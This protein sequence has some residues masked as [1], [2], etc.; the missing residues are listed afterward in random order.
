MDKAAPFVRERVRTVPTG[1]AEDRRVRRT[2]AAL[3]FALIRL[4]LEKRY[5]A[6]TIQNLL[7]RADVGRSTFYSHFRGKDDL[8]L[9]SWGRL[10]EGLD[11][12]MDQCCE[13]ADPARR[14][15]APVREL[16]SHVAKMKPFHQALARARMLDRM[17]QVGV[18]Q[19]SDTIARRLTKAPLATAGGTV[20][21][22]VAA[23]AYAGA[24]FAMLRWWVDHDAPHTPEWMDETY[25][26]IC[27]PD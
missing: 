1:G 8:L 7:D 18:V 17:Y 25:H 3:I 27:R 9:R 15:V 23:Q 11:R 26:A 13:G 6:I 14:R 10:L 20:P 16:F 4:V 2:H 24:L 19:L 21:T 12:D 5:E 22:P